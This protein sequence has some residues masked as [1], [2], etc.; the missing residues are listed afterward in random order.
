MNR[1]FIRGIKLKQVIIKYLNVWII[2][3]GIIGLG[4]YVYGVHQTRTNSIILEPVEIVRDS[5]RSV[6]DSHQ[7]NRSIQLKLFD[8]LLTIRPTTLQTWSQS[9]SSL[10]AWNRRKIMSYLQAINESYSDKYQLKPFQ[11]SLRGVVYL[12]L[13]CLGRGINVEVTSDRIMTNLEDDSSRVIEVEYESKPTG[14]WVSSFE[15]LS[16]YIEVDL[17]SQM[18]FVYQS[19][20]LV[21]STAIV[22]G[23]PSTPTIP[24]VYRILNKERDKT[25]SGKH[26]QTQRPYRIQ[27]DFWM[28]FDERGQGFHDATWLTNFGG[29]IYQDY[30]SLGCLNVSPGSMSQLYE[31]VEIS[32]PVIILP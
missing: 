27:V 14:M 32:T 22:S 4:L 28:V 24:G 5:K 30:G 8:T 7:I 9:Q 25:L 18:C 20:N 19:G 26:P 3:V 15:E 1:T 12:P 13:G 21:Y 2:V 6:V 23:H 11:S 16:N 29:Q 17:Q 10:K 31:L